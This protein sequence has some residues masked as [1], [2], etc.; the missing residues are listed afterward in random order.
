VEN[1]TPTNLALY[2]GVCGW[3][4]ARGHARASGNAIEIAAYLGTSDRFDQA[5]ASFAEA[6]ANQ[7]ERDHR[8]LLNAIKS[9][10]LTAA[11]TG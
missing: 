2:G 7:T 3:A 10:R 6:Y 5:I 8:A 1:L 11:E 4:L 9:G